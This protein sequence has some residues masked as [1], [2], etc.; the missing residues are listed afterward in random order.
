MGTALVGDST[1]AEVP[2]VEVD[3]AAVDSHTVQADDKAAVLVGTAPEAVV[4]Q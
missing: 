4:E 1:A 2:I 3:T